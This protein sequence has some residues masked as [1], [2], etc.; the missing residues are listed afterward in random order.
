[1]KKVLLG[2][3]LACVSFFAKAQEITTPPPVENPN[4]AIITFEKETHDFGSLEKGAFC[5]Y[6]F[7]FTNTGK[8]PLVISNATASCGCTV[9]SY[10]RE[11]IM[12]GKTGSIKVKYD[13]NRI[14]AFQKEVS[15]TSNAKNAL[16]KLTIKGK[17]NEPPKEEM[18]PGN[19][20]NSGAPVQK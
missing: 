19:G 8:E 17:I 5:E 13:S 11:P 12:P 9:P 7:K 10:P 20:N 16:V 15:I 1:M 3:G 4:A 2:L 14:G 18:F 6:E